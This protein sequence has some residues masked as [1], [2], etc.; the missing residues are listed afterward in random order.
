MEGRS[1]F[2]DVICR[3]EHLCVFILEMQK[4]HFKYLPIRLMF[5]D[6]HYFNSLISKGRQGFKD[7]PPVICICIVEDKLYPGEQNYV[8]EFMFRDTETGKI[9]SDKAQVRLIELG[10]FPILQ[11]NFNSIETDA[12]KLFWTMKYAHLI[13]T[14]KVS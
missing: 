14:S 3:D 5:Y 4:D 6:F 12:D 2:Y 10:K 7:V 13:D 8:W 11:N 1:G 9:L